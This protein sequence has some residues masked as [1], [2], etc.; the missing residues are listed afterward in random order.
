[1]TDYEKHFYPNNCVILLMLI[2]KA[3]HRNISIETWQEIL[4]KIYR[5][6]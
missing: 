2:I 3:Q 1:M 4:Q 5:I 6:I